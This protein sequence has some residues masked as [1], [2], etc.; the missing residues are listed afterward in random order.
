MRISDQLGDQRP[1]AAVAA[2]RTVPSAPSKAE[3]QDQLKSACQQVEAVF[4]A[5]LLHKMRET[6]PKDPL[7][8]ESRATDIYNGMLDWE[9]AQQM[10]R[11]QSVGIAEMLYRQLSRAGGAAPQ[12]TGKS[13]SPTAPAAANS[14][15]VE[16]K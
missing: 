8:G 12:E 6:V 11:T 7:L 16:H 9:L 13:T 3:D 1:A 2:P 15:A 10:A 14:P 4:L 5:H